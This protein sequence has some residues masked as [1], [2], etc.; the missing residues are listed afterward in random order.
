MFNEKC[1]V[2]YDFKL[3]CVEKSL[4]G[5][6]PYSKA[7]NGEKHSITYKALHILTCLEIKVES[8]SF[9]C[10]DTLQSL[11]KSSASSNSI[12]SLS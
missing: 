11:I 4:H 12:S 2:K 10:T 8:L 7:H 1:P 5:R 6:Y 3:K 9:E